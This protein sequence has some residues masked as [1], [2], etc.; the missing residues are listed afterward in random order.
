M[1][2]LEGNITA[3]ATDSHTAKRYVILL[4]REILSP[5]IFDVRKNPLH[6]RSRI[7]HPR[8]KAL[9]SLRPA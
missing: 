9:P 2:T 6:T 8:L 5:A 7:D 3:T 4:A 1:V